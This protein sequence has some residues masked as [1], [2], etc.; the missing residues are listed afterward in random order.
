MAESDEM[1]K[2]QPPRDDVEAS[3]EA[4]A[5]PGSSS[6]LM[7]P[8]EESPGLGVAQPHPGILSSTMLMAK[9][10]PMISKMQGK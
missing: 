2:A 6:L 4:V 3:A 8:P 9:R 1:E 10:E 5:K 7:A